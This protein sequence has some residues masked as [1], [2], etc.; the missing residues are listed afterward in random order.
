MNAQ[1]ATPIGPA[2][3]QPAADEPAVLNTIQIPSAYVSRVSTALELR[4][5]E[6][7]RV[8]IAPDVR[9]GRLVVLAPQS[10][11]RQIE[12]DAITVYTAESRPGASKIGVSQAVAEAGLPGALA[13]GVRMAGGQLQIQLTAIDWRTFEASLHRVAGRQIPVTTS[14]NGQR[15]VFQLAGAPLDGTSIE[16]DRSTNRVTVVAPEPSMPGWQKMIRSLDNSTAKPGEVTE[17]V[18][19]ENARPAPI[20][21][22]LQLID[23]LPVDGSTTVAA[24]SAAGAFRTAALPQG[25][26]NAQPQQ[27]RGQAQ[28]QPPAPQLPPPAPDNQAQ[29]DDQAA[30]NAAAGEEAAGIIGDTQ[31]QFVPELGI[32][33]V[34]GA[35]RDT[36]RVL[37]VIRQIEEQ[38]AVTQ[39]E[40]EIFQLKH[41]N[42]VAAADLLNEVYEEVLAARQGEV[43]I[44][45]LDQPNAILLVGR[46][47]SVAAAI[48]L[49]EKLDQP[50]DSTSRLRV[51]PLKHASARDVETTVRGFF[52]EKPGSEED[53]RPGLGTRVRVIA[54]YRTNALVIGASP[55]DLEE[56]EQLI[57][58]ID[59]E[60]V[61]AQNEIRVFPLKNS[62]ADDLAPVIQGAINGEGEA[63]AAEDTTR[64]STSLSI[65]AVDS[66]EGQML[67]SGIL[68]NLVVTADAN[69]NA[70]IVRGPSSSMELVGE[71]IRQLDQVPGVETVVK[72][73]TVENGDATQLTTALN[74]LFGATTQQGGGGGGAQAGGGGIIGQLSGS[75]SAD[76]SLVNLRFTTD[77]RTNSIIATGSDSDL[78]VV[79]SIL[80][81]L[82]TKGFAE[83]I[84]EVIWLRHQ[85]APEI[86]AAIQQYVQ[87]RTQTVNTIQ[88][89]QQG[90]GALDLPDRDLIVVAEEVSNSLLLS[91]SPRVY[92]DVR[93][94]IEALDRRP[95]MVMIKV[96]LAEVLL[97][98]NF[99]LGGEL[100]LQ[101]SLLFDRSVAAAPVI[102]D[103]PTDSGFNFNNNGTANNAAILPGNIGSQA[104]TTFGLG[105]ASQ[106]TGYGG[107]VLS[108]ASDSFSLLLRALQDANR[109]Q[110]LSRPQI[111][112]V[113]NKVGF[114]QV[115]QR[116]A[117]VIGLSQGSINFAPLLNVQDIDIGLILEVL[118]RVGAD[119]LISM[120][121]RAERSDIDTTNAGTPIGTD[122]EGNPI[123]IPN[124]NRTNAESTIVAYSGQTVV[125]GGLI[126]KE[127]V[128]VSRRVPYLSNIPLLGIFFRFDREAEERRELLVI[129]TPMLVNGDE[130]LEYI[131]RVESSRMSYCLADIVE[132][133]GDVG[134]SEGYGLWGP[135]VGATI[136]PDLQPT[137][138]QFPTANGETIIGERTVGQSVLTG[139]QADAMF[140]SA[141]TTDGV[142][143]NS[144]TGTSSTGEGMIQEAPMITDPNNSGSLRERFGEGYE[145]QPSE[146]PIRRETI[147]APS[148]QPL[149]N[150]VP[151]EPRLFNEPATG[152]TGPAANGAV[153]GVANGNAGQ[154]LLPSQG[155]AIQSVPNQQLPVQSAPGTNLPGGGVPNQPLPIQSNQGI[156]PQGQGPAPQANLTPG[157]QTQ[158]RLAPSGSL[159]ERFTPFR[160]NPAPNGLPTN[161]IPQSGPAPAAMQTPPTTLRPVG[162]QGSGGPG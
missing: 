147:P 36:Q 91:C 30:G 26:A 45:P 112:T 92:Q 160:R 150:A 127:R 90:L 113:D 115:G 137:V 162:F 13:S 154:G 153:N 67:S 133:H 101:D 46:R 87:Q 148:G 155:R 83:R 64:P 57:K 33:I 159:R 100:G 114:V 47:E 111:M 119:G 85:T 151:P 89:F 97:S 7:A 3:P 105:A 72:V 145:G 23:S 120:L 134:L 86:A 121:I 56:V 94:L 73:F 6:T 116:V 61:P 139:P 161:N 78:E 43:N 102:P 20:Q 41:L 80:L 18:R 40:V 1:V 140:Q 22:A 28:P 12:S 138:D 10:I 144:P 82:D 38:S 128:N 106:T 136:Y 66:E 98:D 9:G 65:L 69:A 63:E 141:P 117:R 71:L 21:R 59:V 125:F 124:I 48:T 68:A 29:G 35:K 14:Q 130:D 75:T 37:D 8:H 131:K 39:P 42:S 34:R 156:V 79:E 44:R 107:F 77:V 129:M 74:N 70:L 84:T 53:D 25:V 108:A 31:I 118:P 52:V 58:D 5:R 24:T 96:V 142:I 27:P 135:A 143:I 19:L 51:F 55:R 104:L 4:Y 2:I 32:I 157:V 110:I 103:V 93:Q 152:R 146:M 54:D 16:V 76:S 88:Q 11:Q 99:E 15:A 60:T 149:D 62:R 17:L 126:Q 132:M 123:V 95:P 109:A 81:R 50:L 158:N 49:I 122:S